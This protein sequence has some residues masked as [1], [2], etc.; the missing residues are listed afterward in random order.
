MV[1]WVHL[2]GCQVEGG[3]RVTRFLALTASFGVGLL[4]L[5]EQAGAQD[6][7][8]TAIVELGG[9]AEWDLPNGASSFGPTAS[10]EFTPIKDWL[11]IETGVSALYGHG[12]TEWGYDLI[13]KKPFTLSD[14]VEFMI[15]A[16]PEWT[17]TT[18]GEGA[19]L[20]AEVA[21]EFMIWPTKDRK[22]GWFIEPTYSYALTSDH[23]K[24]LGLAAGLMIPIP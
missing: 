19:K 22:F 15:G 23:Q 12:Q 24:S 14:K 5:V 6:K 7:E 8:P 17:Y 2:G 9:A 18:G 4:G 13:F 16:G 11:E 20:S 1:S 21:A 3:R 10:V